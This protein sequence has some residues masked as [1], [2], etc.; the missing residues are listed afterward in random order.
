MTDYDRIIAAYSDAA[1]D[2]APR[3]DRLNA[4]AQFDCV[5]ALLPPGGLALD[6]GA[7]S[8][9]DAGWLRSRGFEVVA[10]EPAAAMRSYGEVAH[11]EDGIRWLDD[12]LPGLD[13]THRLGLA[14]D[15]IML[16]VVWQH[17]RPSY[18][19]RA[20]RKMATLLR[21]GGLLVMSLR[22]GPAPSDRPMHPTSV[23]EIEGLA[24]ISGLEV[25]RIVD[26]ADLQ[27][28]PGVTWSIICL[29]LPDDGTGALPLVRGIILADGKSSTHK[30][31]LL[32]AVARIAEHGPRTAIPTPGAVDSVD[33]PLGLVA[34]NWV[35]LYLPLVKAGLPQAPRNSAPDGL[36]FAKTGFRALIAL[37][38]ASPDLRI[39]APLSGAMADATSR[40]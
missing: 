34:L 15:M 35:R 30:L 12:R 32:R 11:A 8:V 19:S 14:F 17:V 13:R 5:A 26:R 2:L 9:R 24:R 1:D 40:A 25:V 33:V 21:P 37:G 18:R 16:S 10:A 23:G 3:Y 4:Q 29:R 6:I 22:N 38:A 28:R 39:G 20:V 7:G 27:Q 36:A 31:G